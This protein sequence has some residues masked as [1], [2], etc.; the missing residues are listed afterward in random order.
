MTL[1]NSFNE[2]SARSLRTL[3]VVS[4]LDPSS[5]GPAYSVPRL[6]SAL[7]ARGDQPTVFSVANA[8]DEPCDVVAGDYRD[9]RFAWDYAHIPVLQRLRMSNDMSLALEI[10]AKNADVVHNHGIWQMPNIMAGRAASR[11]NKPFV[12]STR[13]MLAPEALAFS[14]IRKRVF[15]KAIQGAAVH[16]AACLHATSD[17]EYDELREFG[18]MS[19]VAVIPNGIDVPEFVQASPLQQERVLLALGRIHP[20]KGFDILTRAWAQVMSA[21]PD[22]QLRIIGPAEAGH[23][24][25]LRSLARSLGLSRFSVEGPVYGPAKNAILRDA[26]LF[27]LPSLNENFGLTVAEALAVGTPVISSKGAP[28]SGLESEGCGWWVDLGVESF[29]AA[30][31]RAM[32]MPREALKAMGA[33]GRAWMARDYSWNSVASDMLSVYRWLA[34]EAEAPR[35]VRFDENALARAHK[36]VGSKSVFADALNPVAMR[37]QITPVIITYNEAPNIERTLDKLFWARRIVVVDSGSSDK[38]ID[39]LSRS[40]HVAIFRRRFTNFAEQWNFG[41][42]QVSTPWVL[43]LDADYELSERFIDEILS[44]RPSDDSVGYSADFVY[45]IYGRAL[46]GSLYPK[47]TLLFR[48]SEAAYEMDGHTQRLIINGGVQHLACPVYHDDRKS[49]SRWFESQ[50]RYAADEANHLLSVPRMQ[51]SRAD[52]LRLMVW[53]AP[54][55]IFLYVLLVKGCIFDGWPGWLYALQRTIAEMLLS[56]ALI[57]RKLSR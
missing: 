27:V 8:G 20:K 40:P 34:D 38:T 47:R 15:W 3:H 51:L 44:L 43:S 9:R 22:W 53:P 17:Q 1:A 10:A 30:L 24:E 56:I 32:T 36:V 28:W 49:L 57:E 2:I 41:L 6:C 33:K 23:D 31:A 26:D 7:G 21:F 12:V 37:D 50:Q 42:E 18:L 29:A 25:E 54:L 45:R 39:I 11:L 48:K 52:K 5:G 4:T 46:R 14:R 35:V 13:G 19:P 16:R 55:G